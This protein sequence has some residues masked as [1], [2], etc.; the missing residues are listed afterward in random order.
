MSGIRMKHMTIASVMAVVMDT[1]TVPRRTPK[2]AV[3]KRISETKS[4]T[5]LEKSSKTPFYSIEP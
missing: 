1:F 2:Y 5:R 3:A 4:Q